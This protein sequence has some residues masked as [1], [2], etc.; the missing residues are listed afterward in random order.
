ME[1]IQ[2]KKNYVELYFQC[3]EDR[4]GEEGTLEHFAYLYKTD[5]IIAK[6]EEL[7]AKTFK[8]AHEK[9]YLSIFLQ[10]TTYIVF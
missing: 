10:L 5:E 7:L 1:E 3:D 6:C 8:L 2:D 9:K 4:L